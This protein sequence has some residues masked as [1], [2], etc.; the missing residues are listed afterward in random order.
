MMRKHNVP[1]QIPQYYGA[2]LPDNDA[3]EPPFLLLKDFSYCTT[4]SVF[5]GMS[6]QQIREVR[7]C[8]RTFND[9]ILRSP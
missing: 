9:S 7:W 1:V 6:A 8:M 5:P 2:V 4:P 3:K